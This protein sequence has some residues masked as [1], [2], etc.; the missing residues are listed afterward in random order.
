[1]NMTL[2]NQKPFIAGNWKLHKTNTE[3]V[4]LVQSILQKIRNISPEDAEIVVM[5]P[6]TA[7]SPVKDILRKSRV[8]LGAQ[9]LHWENEGAFTGEI[10]A[11]ML[12]DAGC[13][14]VVVGH[15]ERRQ[16][17]G[18]TN[19]SVNKKIKAAL[20]CQLLPVMCIG[21]TLEE[22]ENGKTFSKIEKQI[23]EGL[24][25]ITSD[26]VKNIIIAYEPI[27][28]IGTGRTASPEQAGEVHDVIREKLVEKYGKDSGECVIILYGGS[29]KPKNTYP[30]VKEKNVNGALIG[31]AS[32]QA[33]SFAEIAKEAIKA[34]REK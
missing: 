18:E 29:V 33:G 28:A 19:L 16:Y 20:S 5:P 32:L 12:K 11:P 10:S 9:N 30:L 24:E 3:A 1:M 7:L 27:W 14:F 4:E 25:H 26:Q 2:T 6:F 22:R 23:S 34:Y 8:Q 13:R 21:E 15:S 31:G 17:F